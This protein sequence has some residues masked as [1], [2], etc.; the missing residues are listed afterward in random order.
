M[1][2]LGRPG[3]AGGQE[4]GVSVRVHWGELARAW[5]QEQSLAFAW[6]LCI[7]ANHVGGGGTPD[8]WV[9]HLS[10][11]VCGYLA[12]GGVPTHHPHSHPVPQ[13]WWEQPRAGE[14]VSLYELQLRALGTGT[15]A[16]T[17]WFC[18][19]GPESLQPLCPGTR[20]RLRLRGLNPAGPGA[21]GPPYTVSQGWGGY[22]GGWGEISH[23]PHFLYIQSSPSTWRLGAHGYMGGRGYIW[24]LEYIG[25]IGIHGS[26]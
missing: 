24:V 26:L 12:G 19:R 21:W 22:R 25:S 7:C 10:V 18:P 4:S 11:A 13:V 20:Y 15:L 23:A 3:I 14:R 16:G 5:G 1:A 8:T 6:I 9:P 17:H 2:G